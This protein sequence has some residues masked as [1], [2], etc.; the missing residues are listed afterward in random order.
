VHHGIEL[1]LRHRRDPAAARSGHAGVDD[2]QIELIT[3]ER[4]RQMIRGLD[5]T[6]P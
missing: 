2:R 1:R 3:G 6:S 4:L 5:S